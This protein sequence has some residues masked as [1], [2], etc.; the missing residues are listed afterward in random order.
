MIQ[1]LRLI[2]NPSIFKAKTTGL[3][4]GDCLVY[5]MSSKPP[6]DTHTVKLVSKPKQNKRSL[7]GISFHVSRQLQNTC[8]KTDNITAQTQDQSATALSC[9]WHRV[10]CT[11]VLL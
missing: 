11:T 4:G 9:E 5:I 6:W 7:L 8:I 10:I 1:N 2:Y 3:G